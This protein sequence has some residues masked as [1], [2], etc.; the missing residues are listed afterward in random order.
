MNF[1]FVWEVCLA[2]EE[3]QGHLEQGVC[4][5]QMDSQGHR[6]HLDHLVQEECKDQMVL[7]VLTVQREKEDPMALMELLELQV[8]IKQ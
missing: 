3:H 1:P 8:L 2:Q 5:D 6:D 4:K 7:Q